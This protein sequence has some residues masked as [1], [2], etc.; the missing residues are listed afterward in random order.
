MTKADFFS[1]IS[2]LLAQLKNLLALDSHVDLICFPCISFHSSPLTLILSPLH[3]HFTYPFS[4]HLI[5]CHLVVSI[6][7]RNNV[8]VLFFASIS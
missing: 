7:G 5:N 2:H 8:R 4:A 1:G 6:D 3:I